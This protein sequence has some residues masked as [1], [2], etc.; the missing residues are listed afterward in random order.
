MRVATSGRPSSPARSALAP[1]NVAA[2]PCAADALHFDMVERPGNSCAQAWAR[3]TATWSDGLPA[4]GASPISPK[5][6]AGQADQPSRYRLRR[7]ISL[8]WRGCGARRQLGA[9]GF[10]KATRYQRGC[11][12]EATGGPHNH[13]LARS[14]P[15]FTA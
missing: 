5:R 4:Q 9:S 2:S 14:G 10:R 7:S 3:T 6:S 8:I 1:T 15:G 13:V 12:P 11:V